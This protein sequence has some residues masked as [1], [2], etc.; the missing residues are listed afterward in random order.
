LA[1]NTFTWD[2]LTTF[3]DFSAAGDGAPLPIVL[4]SFEA[5]PVGN[6]VLVSWTTSSEI[7]NDYFTIERSVDAVNYASIGTVNG[8]GNSNSTNNY[9]FT[10]VQPMMGISYYR[11]R[12]TDFNGDL[13]VFDPAVVNFGSGLVQGAALFPNPA[14]EYAHVMIN[15]A[16]SGKG[17]VRVTDVTGRL[18]SNFQIVM[19]KGMTPFT[20]QT[21]NLAPGKYLVTVEAADGK[22]YNLPLMKN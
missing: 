13:E 11:L 19:T 6:T 10:D 14:V 4:L 1:L 9:T 22:V 8:A 2:N 3:S 15:T 20:L 12:Q 16:S 7:N 17:W 5:E 21:D 18:I